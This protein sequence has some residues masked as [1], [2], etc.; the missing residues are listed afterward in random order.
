MHRETVTRIRGVGKMGQ[1]DMSPG[2]IPMLKKF[3]RAF[4][5]H[6]IATWLLKG[7][8]NVFYMAT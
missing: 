6:I 1:G 2:E 5:Y 7:K 4:G 8:G 3:L